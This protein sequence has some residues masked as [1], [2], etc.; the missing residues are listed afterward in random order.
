MAYNHNG[1]LL[2]V[3]IQLSDDGTNGPSLAMTAGIALL[4]NVAMYLGYRQMQKKKSK[5][6]DRELK[7]AYAKFQSKMDRINEYLRES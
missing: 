4:A 7:I 3:P 5:S 1:Y 2:K 6:K